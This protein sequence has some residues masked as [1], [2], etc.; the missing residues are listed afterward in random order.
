MG[1]QQMDAERELTETE[2][3]FL[4]GKCHLFAI[5]LHRLTGLPL[6]AT[7]DVE[8]WSERTVLV[9]AYVIDGDDRIDVRGRF[10]LE[11]IGELFEVAEPW[12]TPIGAEDLM[13]IGT[14][15]RRLND[16]GRDFRKAAA[17]AAELAAALDLPTATPRPCPLGFRPPLSAYRSACGGRD[18][19]FPL[20]PE[21]PAFVFH[22]RIRVSSDNHRIDPERLKH[23]L[24]NQLVYFDDL[25]R[26]PEKSRDDIDIDP[27]GG[28]CVLE[29]GAVDDPM[30]P[31][32]LHDAPSRSAESERRP[33]P[34]RSP[35]PPQSAPSGCDEIVRSSSQYGRRSSP[36][37]PRYLCSSA[38]APETA[39][40]ATFCFKF[41][42]SYSIMSSAW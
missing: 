3:M 6:A 8:P 41:M 21:E 16:N 34:A 17:L 4:H 27:L 39:T 2:E 42:D 5:A 33:R 13:L 23:F 22:D 12:E 40:I 15:R 36:S 18:Q 24:I 29:V 28:E 7:L 30:R 20:R 10:G 25:S 26:L 35:Y 38:R 9:H 11:D 19:S 37:G 32:T 1:M 14:G 31:E